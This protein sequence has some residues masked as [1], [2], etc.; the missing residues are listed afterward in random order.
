M[1]PVPGAT[2]GEAKTVGSLAQSENWQSLTVVTNRPHTRRVRMTFEQC[3]TLDISV[4]SIDN[5]DVVRAPVRIA[6]E[7]AGFIN[8]GLQTLA[9]GC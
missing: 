4:V 9:E 2:M 8:S 5:V 6:R 3:T 1:K 7:I